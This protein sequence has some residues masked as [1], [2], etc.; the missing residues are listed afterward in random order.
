MQFVFN[1]HSLT[2]CCYCVYCVR[3][4]FGLYLINFFTTTSLRRAHRE[5]MEL[6]MKNGTEYTYMTKNDLKKY[7]TLGMIW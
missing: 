5:N 3:V 7:K 1:A 2:K 4:P 6:K